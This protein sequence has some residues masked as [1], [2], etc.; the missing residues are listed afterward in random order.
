MPAYSRPVEAKLYVHLANGEK[1]EATKDDLANF[2][3]VDRLDTYI[4]FSDHLAQALVAAG[5]IERHKHL[6]RAKLN[7]LRYLAETAICHPELLTHP[8][9]AETDADIVAIEQALRA[10]NVPAEKE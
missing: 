7:P 2:G 3:Y 9:F 8:E 1:F 4:R 10:A 6:T 5:L